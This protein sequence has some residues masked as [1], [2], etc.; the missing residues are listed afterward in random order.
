MTKKTN[1]PPMVK[2]TSRDFASIK[3]DLISHAK[4]YYPNTFQDFSEASFGSMMLDTVAYVG[5]MISFYLD[6]QANES[7]IDSAVEPEN[8]RRHARRL[9]YRHS[10]RAGTAQG[11]IALYLTVPANAT[12]GGPNLDYAPV[13]RRGATFK[14]TQGTSYVLT[15]DVD[16]GNPENETV[17]AAVDEDN[18][19]TPTSFAIKTRG[20]VISGAY[21]E[22][23]I[24]IGEYAPFR[25]VDIT[26]SRIV[27]IVSVEDSSGNN[28]YE[29]DYLS[30]DVVY[31]PVRN[32][33][34][35]NVT[36][37]TQFLIKPFAVPRRF[38]ADY[39]AGAVRLVFG[40]G[41]PNELSNNLVA[42]PAK[43]VL[44]QYAKDY[45]SDRSFD[46]ARLLQTGTLGVGPE[47]TT[48]RITYRI[49]DGSA[50]SSANAQ[51]GTINEILKAETSWKD[52][53]QLATATMSTIAQSLE[54]TNE[55]PIIG[56]H[57]GTDI[58]SI[59][60]LARGASAAQNRCVTKEDYC[61]AVYS[62]PGQFGKIKRCQI[63]Q[64]HDSHKRN[65]NMYVISS[66]PQDQL[67]RT[68]DSIKNNVKAWLQDKKMINDTI[69]IMDARIVNFG[70]D[71]SIVVN[72]GYNRYDTLRAC[73]EQLELYFALA[74]P[75]IGEAFNIAALYKMINRVTGVTD[76]VDINVTQKSGGVYSDI[77]FNIYAQTTP[78]QLYVKVPTD[79]IW[80]V[81]NPEND[82]K[83]TIH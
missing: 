70:I 39:T 22:A 73:Q 49:N 28:Y 21:Y 69:D 31:R 18:S 5:D 67:M 19:N 63:T 10:D 27:E 56:D 29:V 72:P 9:G 52:E 83:G 53:S 38:T 71:Y 82:C 13:I 14:S 48:L 45:I 32:P 65:L 15:E 6:Y 37:Q 66:G 81:L 79:V 35:D 12:G 76:V 7:F 59:R 50:A 41:S 51:T 54:V 17:V 62:M 30:Q 60:A 16:F 11:V 2:Y 44:N 36:G 40:A 1:R 74:N 61:H 75:L 3:D 77:K 80:E 64:D 23:D 57:T 78:D 46:P 42:D 55:Q 68:P 47:N 24:P 34:Y 58:N 4:R 33:S 26:D 8:V 43:V 25:A 20:F